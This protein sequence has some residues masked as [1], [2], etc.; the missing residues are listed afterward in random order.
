M[1]LYES[2]TIRNGIRFEKILLSPH[3][4]FRDNRTHRERIHE[5]LHYFTGYQAQLGEQRSQ[6][7]KY[8]EA[9][10]T[11]KDSITLLSSCLRLPSEYAEF[12][13]I[14]ELL[15]DHDEYQTINQLFQALP[16][17]HDISSMWRQW[18]QQANKNQ[19]DASETFT[20]QN[21]RLNNTIFL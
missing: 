4:R 2:M 15:T 13:P 5:L 6:G 17:Y 9:L 18:I 16:I 3:Y 11:C 1:R 21:L 12:G 7:R 8:T 20:P 10:S 14:H 19:E